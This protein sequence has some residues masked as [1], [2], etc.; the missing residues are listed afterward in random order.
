[1]EVIAGAQV[2]GRACTCLQLR[3]S[4]PRRDVEFHVVRLFIDDEWQLPVR[5]EGY[6]FP[7]R[8]GESPRLAAEYTFL[9]IKWNAGLRDADFDPRNS[10][11]EFKR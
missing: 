7:M 6:A 4:A 9:R 3:H 10:A 1:M 11:Y 5:S 2:D 8:A